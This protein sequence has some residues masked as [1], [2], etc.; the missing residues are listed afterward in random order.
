MR[1]SPSD[2]WNPAIHLV[3]IS[4]VCSLL[5]WFCASL[6]RPSICLPLAHTH[7]W[8]LLAVGLAIIQF[9]LPPP[10]GRSAPAMCPGPGGQRLRTGSSPPSCWGPCAGWTRCCP[11]SWWRRPP[12]A[13]ESPWHRP[14]WLGAA[15]TEPPGSAPLPLWKDKGWRLRNKNKVFS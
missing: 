1:T 7:T 15:G 13:P 14:R 5:C 6:T 10:S 8:S 3:Q 2:A 11:T 9:L 4:S 12:P